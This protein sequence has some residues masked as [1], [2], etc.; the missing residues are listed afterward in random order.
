MTTCDFRD[1][2]QGY[3]EGDLPAA[4]ARVFRAHLE[5][6][7]ACAAEL[8][9][10]RRVFTM[11]D[12]AP[13]LEPR[14]ELTERVLEQVLPS[15]VWARRAGRLRAFGWGYAAALTASLAAVATW[16]A[17]PEGQQALSALSVLASRRLLDG[18]KLAV[19]VVS[20][21]LVQ[22]ASVGHAV[23]DVLG[24]FAPLGRA[25]LAVLS[26]ASILGP[27]LAAVVISATMLWWLRPRESRPS[28]GVR[29][30]GVLG[31]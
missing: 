10:Y 11:L 2:I 8:A 3:L 1:R 16:V 31:F 23:G 17:R 19:Q 26:Q 9:V 30:V 28:R 29:H 24:R 15:R 20:F 14:P 27:L 4:E 25:L 6:C 18:T 12:E 13:L 21:A 5:G 22:M 7:A